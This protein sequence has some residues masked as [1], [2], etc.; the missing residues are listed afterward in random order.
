M[1]DRLVEQFY[2][3]AIS[4]PEKIA[5][6]TEKS[7]MSYSDLLGLVHM[8]DMQLTTRG[9]REGQTIVLA[10]NRGELC[11][12]FALLISLRSLTG[13]FG[14]VSSVVQAELKF[15]RVLTLNLSDQIPEH[16]QIVIE[17]DWFSL[18]GATSMPPYENLSGDGGRYVTQSSGTT[19]RTKFI[20]TPE[21]SRL[22]DMVHMKRHSAAE[23]QRM[24]FMSSSAPS[25]GWALNTNMPVLLAGGSIV[26]LSDEV[27]RTLQYID[28]YHV[29]H[30]GTT[31]ALLASALGIKNASQYMTSLQEVEVAGAYAPPALLS[32]LAEMCP[33][34]RILTAYGASETGALCRAAFDPASPPRQGYLGDFFRDDL[35][36]DFFDDAL[37][38]KPGASS[39]ILGIRLP[40]WNGKCYVG[41]AQFDETSGFVGTHFLPGDIVRYD[42]QGLHYEGRTKNVLN[43]NANKYSLDA[44]GQVL[45]DAFTGASI[46]PVA[47][48]DADGLEQLTVFYVASGMIGLAAINAVVQNTWPMVTAASA[49][50]LP[51][52]PMT[53]SGKVDVQTLRL[54]GDQGS[55]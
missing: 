38:L 20:L 24:R 47:T 1:G 40:A 52:F 15:D 29:T 23:L 6:I 34:L 19:G 12:A 14:S 7:Q 37:V 31:P 18:I 36:L 22:S 10:T 41:S 50:R 44:I 26:A 53:Q 51:E 27:D 4:H 11:I 25:T 21:Q 45:S 46:I 48:R 35:S 5:L 49:R 43:L 30:L 39:G 8:L 17:A 3:T 42:G 16:Q 2:R 32:R 55:A 33:Q 9:V 28:L 13:I 54:L